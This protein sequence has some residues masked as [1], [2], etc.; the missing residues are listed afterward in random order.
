MADLCPRCGAN[1]AMVGR[2]HRCIDRSR[3]SDLAV[4]APAERLSAQSSDAYRRP[5]G[6]FDRL[7][8]QRDYMRKYR[9][10]KK[11]IENG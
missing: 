6:K 7:A 1:L 4:E 10:K 2:A 9:A 8:Y 11:G 3:N 5:D